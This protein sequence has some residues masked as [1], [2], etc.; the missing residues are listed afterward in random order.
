MHHRASELSRTSAI[1]PRMIAVL[2]ELLYDA[3][4]QA[5]E[6]LRQCNLQTFQAVS[7]QIESL[8]NIPFESHSPDLSGFNPHRK[9]VQ[10][11]IHKS[12]SR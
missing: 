4:S 6:Q 3:T 9:C 2:D 5:G 11:G 10:Y 12:R 1:A 8:G 7:L